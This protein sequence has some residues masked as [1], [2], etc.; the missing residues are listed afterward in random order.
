MSSLRRKAPQ[1]TTRSIHSVS[2][3]HESGAP[4]ET[5]IT[6]SCVTTSE[7]SLIEPHGKRRKLWLFCV[8]AQELLIWR[9]RW[10]YGI[11]LHLPDQYWHGGS[12]NK[13]GDLA[14][15]VEVLAAAA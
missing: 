10:C 4:D 14:S 8:S 12:C 9:G 11:T 7:L 13:G 2:I 3:H 15:I 6:S 5:S 1:S